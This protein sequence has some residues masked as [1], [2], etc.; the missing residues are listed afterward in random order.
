MSESF[1]A[2]LRAEADQIW[3]FWWCT[4][5]ILS[6]EHMNGMLQHAVRFESHRR[7]EADR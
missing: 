3:P 6:G 5:T 4:T 2:T 1:S 7:L